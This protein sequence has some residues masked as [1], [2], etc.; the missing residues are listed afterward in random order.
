MF[1]MKNNSKIFLYSLLSYL[2]EFIVLMTFIA[3]ILFINKFINDSLSHIENFFLAIAISIYVLY[4]L[5]SNTK[6]VSL[7]CSLLKY[8]LKTDDFHYPRIMAGN[9]F[10]YGLFF[11]KK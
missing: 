6:Y 1:K 4:L 7:S 9:F 11:L 3:L 2:I 5:F 8:R 10:F